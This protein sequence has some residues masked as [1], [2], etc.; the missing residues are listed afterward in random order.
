MADAAKVEIGMEPFTVDVSSSTFRLL[1]FIGSLFLILLFIALLAAVIILSLQG[2]EPTNISLPPAYGR[3]LRNATIDSQLGSSSDGTF[4][5][6]PLKENCSLFTDKESC[7]GLTY[8]SPDSSIL[9][10]VWDDNV[11]VCRCLPPYWGPA[12]ERETY[13]DRY[14]AEGNPNDQ[15]SYNIIGSSPADQISFSFP[16]RPSTD[17]VLCTKRCDETPSCSGVIVSRASGPNGQLSCTLLGGKVSVPSPD[18][19]PFDPLVDSTLYLKLGNR[20]QFPNQVFAYA[21]P[22]PLRFWVLPRRRSLLRIDPGLP[23]RLHFVPTALINDGA[24]SGVWSNREISLLEAQQ[25]L[26]GERSDPNVYIA[27]GDEEFQLPPAL[28]VPGK[29]W[30]VYP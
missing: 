5:F 13:S 29:L 21:P 18:D 30:A 9:T 17:Q 3:R 19:L 4:S 24:R 16:G 14:T 27:H 26:D 7:L 12:G 20:P 10:R 22:L 28:W 8:T 15:V 11:G 2:A 6:P 25:L 1:I 23:T